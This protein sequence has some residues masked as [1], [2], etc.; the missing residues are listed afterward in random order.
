MAE[1]VDYCRPLKTSH[2]GFFLDTFK[3]FMKEW[4]GGSYIFMNNNPRVPGDRILMHIEN[5]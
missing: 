3:E 2:K 5:K 4:P 1:G